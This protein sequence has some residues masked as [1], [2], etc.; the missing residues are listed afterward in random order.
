MT[1]V[2]RLLQKWRIRKVTPYI[3]KGM[4][5]LDIG[6]A[7]GLLFT[8]SQNCVSGSVGIDPSLPADTSLP[9]GY[10]L[11]KGFFPNDL[12]DQSGPFDAVV[13][14][15]VL[16]HFP[17]DQHTILASGIAQFLRPGGLLLITVPSAMVDHILPILVKLRLIHGMSLEE[18]HG[19]D[20]THTQNIFPPPHFELVLHQRF[21]LGLNNFFI[22]KRNNTTL[23]A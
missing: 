10:H 4:K 3:K 1:Y 22:F 20:V 12:P 18:H 11:K 14:L 9:G 6:G 17:T 8:F 15:A 5:V 16:E 13:M 2:D 19:Y 7:D 23:T 21:Q